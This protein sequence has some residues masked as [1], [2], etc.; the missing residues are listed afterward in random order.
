MKWSIHISLQ[1]FLKIHI[2]VCYRCTCPDLKKE[3]SIMKSYT[4]KEKHLSSYFNVCYRHTSP[5]MKKKFSTMKFFSQFMI[6]VCLMF[7]SIAP[8]ETL[9][10]GVWTYL[11]ASDTGFCHGLPSRTTKWALK[12]SKRYT[13][14]IFQ[15]KMYLPSLI[16]VNISPKYLSGAHK[17]SCVS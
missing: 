6:L 14:L 16:Q 11:K 17:A 13:V 1:T 5:D 7:K 9:N 8:T 3:F 4:W 10:G 2:T 15:N 12:H